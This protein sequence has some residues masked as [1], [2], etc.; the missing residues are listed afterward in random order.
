MDEVD[1]GNSF[2]LSETAT[3]AMNQSNAP[4]RLSENNPIIIPSS[5]SDT[6]GIPGI[7]VPQESL[8]N[9]IP[10][11]ETTTSA[12]NVDSDGSLGMS[13]LKSLRRLVRDRYNDDDDDN[14]IWIPNQDDT[15][16]KSN[17]MLSNKSHNNMNNSMSLMQQS[18]S[19]QIQSAS[20]QGLRQETQRNLMRGLYMNK[21]ATTTTPLRYV[22]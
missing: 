16:N 7:E 8:M 17:I 2:L 10:T 5:S 12:L 4:Q 14:N 18:T 21:G 15:N 20:V 6:G 22:K 3:R 13:G 19:S 11:D 1:L 9:M